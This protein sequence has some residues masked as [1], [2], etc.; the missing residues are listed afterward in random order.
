M[1]QTLAK[2]DSQLLSSALK[3]DT[4]I[5]FPPIQMLISFYLDSQGEEAF[6]TEQ[7]AICA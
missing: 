3:T 1:T 2:F 5:M 4:L 6:A 7:S